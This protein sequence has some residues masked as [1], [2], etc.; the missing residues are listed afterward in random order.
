M[1]KLIERIKNG[2]FAKNIILVASGTLAAQII[3]TIITPIITRLYAADIYGTLSVYN[4][5]ISILVIASSLAFQKSIPIISDDH[6]AKTMVENCVGILIINTAIVSILC[7]A[8]SGDVF[9]VL[10]IEVLYR[11]RLIIPLGLIIVGLYEIFLQWIYRKQAY[12]LIP[13]TRLMQ[14]IAGG[15]VKLFGG[16]ICPTA[17]VLLSGA[18][19][20]QSAGLSSFIKKIK[21]DIGE[22]DKRDSLKDHLQLLNRQK[23]FFMF[24]LPA[25]FISTF[26]AQIPVLVLSSLYG[27]AVS[28]YYG[29]AYSIINLPISLVVVSISRVVYAECA[30]IGKDNATEL[31]RLGLKISKTIILIVIIPALVCV[32]W[33]PDIF[34]FVFG[35]EWAIAGEFARLMM[36][37]IVS[38]CVVLPVGRLYEILEKQN[39]DFVINLFRVISILFAI[40]IIQSNHHNCYVAV[41]VISTI[42]MIAYLIM[43]IGVFICIN[44]QIKADRKDCAR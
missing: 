12:S 5:T 17:I 18:V 33:G 38:Y 22:D 41:G 19:V 16:F 26:S 8:L 34:A 13:K 39:Y 44:K 9:K 15:L 28:G 11:Y 36:G 4:S 29:L 37:M 14:A 20:N 10:G 40:T 25:D 23:K 7:L 43:Y 3:N 6:K 2:R 21:K 42:N 35:K 31:R 32:L 1:G 27:T 24:S 30:K